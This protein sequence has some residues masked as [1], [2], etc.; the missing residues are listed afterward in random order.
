MKTYSHSAVICKTAN[1]GIVYYLCKITYA[2]NDNGDF[3]YVFIPNYS[4]INLLGS[5]DFQGIPGLNLSLKKERYIRENMVPT[6]ISER[7]PSENRDDFYELLEEVDLEYMEPIEYL[8]RTNK[9]YSGDNFF[10]S[11]EEP[12]TNIEFD[13][14]Y[15]NINNSAY[16]KAIL[17]ELAKGKNISINGGLIDDSNRKIMHTVLLSIYE[18]SVEYHNELTKA[19][20]EKAKVEKRYKGRK[21][22]QVDK[23]SFISMLER[24]NNKEITAL[25]AAELLNISINKYYR[26]KKQIQ[27]S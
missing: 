13:N 5:N 21:P 12:D 19:G 16:I 8:L 18:R 26:L 1:N 23:L 27:N 11:P 17:K 7:V 24:V 2:I 14:Y 4:V 20:R 25:K 22:K 15:K 9:R 3:S 6:F 10:L